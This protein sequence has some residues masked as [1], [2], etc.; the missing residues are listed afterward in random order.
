MV[1]MCDNRK[2]TNAG[3]LSHAAPLAGGCNS[4]KHGGSPV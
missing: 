4:F 3:E 2:I 1:N